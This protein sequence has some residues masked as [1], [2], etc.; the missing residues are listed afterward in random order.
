MF[1]SNDISF[2]ILF[3]DNFCLTKFICSTEYLDL[4]CLTIPLCINFHCLLYFILEI[5][6][7][8]TPNFSAILEDFYPELIKP[9]IS[10]T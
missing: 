10:L 3:S 2:I 6:C 7:L 4:F 1:N 9:I 5:V 8:S